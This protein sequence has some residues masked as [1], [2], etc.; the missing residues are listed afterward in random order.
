M[1][2]RSKVEVTWPAAI[3][4]AVICVAARVPAPEVGMEAVY[5]RT[6]TSIIVCVVV[7]NNTSRK[8]MNWNSSSVN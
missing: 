8:Q 3:V 1:V 4:V 7:G 2:K 6:S 5:G